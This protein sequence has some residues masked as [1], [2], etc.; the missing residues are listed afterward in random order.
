MR[1]LFKYIVQKKNYSDNLIK[2]EYNENRKKCS[3][4]LIYYKIRYIE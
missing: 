1:N 2:K 4:N 3:I